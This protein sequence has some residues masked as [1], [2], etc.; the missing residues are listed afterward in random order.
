MMLAALQ[1]DFLAAMRGE[2]SELARHVCER[3]H[4]PLAATR[5][6]VYRNAVRA[7][8][9]GAL[10]AAF[11]VVEQMVGTAFFNEAADRN[12]AAHPSGSGD[13][14]DLG[15]TF[16][17]FLREY[18]HAAELPYLGDLAAL[19]W[20][21]H[22]AFHAA[23][24]APV[25]VEALAAVP[26][27]AL[28]RLVLVPTPGC[29]QIASVWPILTLWRAHQPGA[30]WPAGF[31]L[32]QGGET[33]AVYREGFECVAQ[34]LDAGSAALLSASL[35]GQPLSMALDAAPFTTDPD[36]GARLMA[37]LGALLA[38]GMIGGTRLADVVE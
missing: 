3:G 23:D 11:P 36:P 28:D 4:P 25:G 16:P 38:A 26:A 9:R 8:Q 30:A 27:D 1:R 13:L 10:A 6:A 20:A 14:H 34:I 24:V 5:I 33:V 21:L 17:D 29:A 12:L 22:R 37:A 7:N 35:A 31:D 18:S 19:E 15:A 32:A 2:S